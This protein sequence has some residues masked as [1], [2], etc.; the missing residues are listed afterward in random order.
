[1][2]AD[3]PTHTFTIEP[4]DPQKHNRTA[5]SCGSAP[6]DN[7]LKLST[8]KQTARDQVRLYVAHM[9]QGSIIGY[10]A[11]RSHSVSAFDMP[12]PWAKKAPRHGNLPA[13]FIAMMGV[14]QQFQGRAIGSIL[15]ADAL[16]RIA[17]LADAIGIWAV[18]LDVLDD[19][20][21]DTLNKR[22]NWYKAHGFQTLPDQPLRMFIPLATVRSMMSD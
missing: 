17:R 4:F 3:T 9:G 2:P 11:L 16:K 8:K 14:D 21:P 20:D 6:V 10:Y 7:Y 1:M 13:A 5:F 15:L 18:F 19:G 12:E 22:C